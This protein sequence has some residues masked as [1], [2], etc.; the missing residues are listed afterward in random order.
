MKCAPSTPASAIC[1][2]MDNAS[3][4]NRDTP[5]TTNKIIGLILGDVQNPYFAEII[6]RLQNLLFQRN[7]MLMQFSS[8]YIEEKE[9]QFIEFCEHAHFAGLILL[10]A[11]D[12]NT[13]RERIKALPFPVVLLNRFISNLNCSTV[14]QDN[15]QCGYLAANH[16]LGLGHPRI[17]FIAGPKNSTS[18]MKRLEG[19]RQALTNCF[20]PV[21]EEEIYYGNLTL[22]DGLRIGEE[23]VKERKRHPK[24]VII[25]NDMMSIGFMDACHRAGVQIPKDLSIVSF[26]DIRLSSL[27]CIDLTTIQQPVPDMCEATV[28]AIFRALEKP[29]A[30]AVRIILSPKLV[31]RSTTDYY[32]PDN[33]KS[34]FGL[35]K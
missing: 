12:S 34:F 19:F 31:V 6:Y 32:C 29:D 17:A 35:S 5:D 30:R 18:S 28:E 33:D 7:Y 21:E 14:V 11:L 25:G 16:L 23:Y 4:P 24:A 9:L 26:D 13:L 1:M 27:S 8:S 2:T 15:F 20:L 22:E 10:S 3:S